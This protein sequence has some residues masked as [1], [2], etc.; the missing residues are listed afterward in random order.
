MFILYLF[1]ISFLTANASEQVVLTLNNRPYDVTKVTDHTCENVNRKEILVKMVDKTYSPD[2][3]LDLC[4]NFDWTGKPGP[5][6]IFELDNTKACKLFHSCTPLPTTGCVDTTDFTTCDAITTGSFQGYEWY[7]NWQ[8]LPTKAPTNAPSQSPIVPTRTPTRAPVVPVREPTNAPTTTPQPTMLPT[9][10]P[11]ADIMTKFTHYTTKR[12]GTN[13]FSMHSTDETLE[14]CAQDCFDDVECQFFNYNIDP[15]NIWCYLFKKGQCSVVSGATQT[16]Y[17]KNPTPAPTSAP[18]VSPT[19][20]PVGPWH[21]PLLV[22]QG[23]FDHLPTFMH[24]CHFNGGL[25][26]AIMDEYEFGKFNMLTV[27][28]GEDVN[29]VK[30]NQPS[31]WKM[32]DGCKMFKNKYG[33]DKRCFIYNN[34]LLSWRYYLLNDE[35]MKL[36]TGNSSI[37]T[38]DRNGDSTFPDSRNIPVFD[39]RAQVPQVGEFYNGFLVDLMLNDENK[40]YIDG[41]FLDRCYVAETEAS[42]IW[43][44]DG[45]GMVNHGY[46]KDYTEHKNIVQNQLEQNGL[47]ILSNP[48]SYYYEKFQVDYQKYFGETVSDEQ[49]YNFETYMQ[50]SSMIHFEKFCANA[51]SM[52][53]LYKAIKAGKE[54][55]AHGGMVSHCN[56]RCSGYMRFYLAAYLYGLE[57]DTKSYFAC[58]EYWAINL[59]NR[60]ELMRFQEYD[61]PLGMPLDRIRAAFPHDV[62]VP[63]SPTFEIESYRPFVNRNTGELQAV[64][65]WSKATKTVCFVNDCQRNT[66]ITKGKRCIGN[67]QAICDS[68]IG[69][70]ETLVPAYVTRAPTGSPT[71]FRSSAPSKSPNKSPTDKPTVFQANQP[72]NSPTVE[73][74]IFPEQPEKVS[75]PFIIGISVTGI[76]VVFIMRCSYL[77]YKGYKRIKPTIDDN[78]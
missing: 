36:I 59:D 21:F 72:T 76:I 4:L 24:T 29:N 48:G 8:I 40:S 56:L 16:Y 70:V 31:E 33:M 73:L 28:K 77:K 26:E 17:A 57:P 60:K 51:D 67:D 65:Y 54:V 9:N 23:W 20:A 71:V 15:N 2:E 49:L 22:Q 38:W 53:K 32:I 37:V 35:Y 7:F 1:L 11:T 19:N 34:A 69:K 52:Y 41:T 68:I 27:E 47:T 74:N 43:S 39:F 10:A 78:A 12:C 25:T 55:Q 61:M 50:E 42:A 13:G 58:H 64:V 14:Q 5:C 63:D 44:A 30:S 18:S 75:I 66:D 45:K 46:F 62:V 3:C 6:I